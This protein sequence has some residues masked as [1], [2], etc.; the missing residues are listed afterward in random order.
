MHARPRLALCTAIA[1]LAGCASSGP[2][3]PSGGPAASPGL[4]RITRTR[5]LRIGMSGEQP[6]LTMTA[7]NGELIGLDIALGRVLAQSM[8]VDARFVQMPFGQ[9]LDALEK[10]EVDLVISGMTITPE[11][12]RRVTFVGPYFTSGKSILT[13]S[14]RLAAAKVPQD[15]DAPEIRLAALAGSTSESFARR[16]T[17]RA[18]LFPTER[19]EEAI[20]RVRDGEV[21]ALVADRETCAIAILR[22]PDAGLIA[23]DTVFTVEPMGIAMPPDDPRLARLVESYLDAL[24]ERG[25]LEKARDFW[26]RDPSWAKELR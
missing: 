3:E 23:P 13:R 14:E 24:R 19:L 15:L 4:E 26:L 6:P 8:G 1:L 20:R 22:H 9:L 18:Q 7:R 12:S 21:D 16:A 25:V 11:R 10:R 5:E 17:P 2:A